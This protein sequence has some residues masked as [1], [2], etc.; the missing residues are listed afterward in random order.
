MK[1]YHGTQE[2]KAKCIED[3]GFLGGEL[4]KLTIGRHIE[5]GVVYF[6]DTAEEA[7]EYGDVVFEVDLEGVEVQ[8]FSDGNTTHYYAKA[9][10]VN[11]QASWERQ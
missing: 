2:W 11:A 10:D 6:A 4:D 5:G 7:G 9:D 8:P 1:L 3:E